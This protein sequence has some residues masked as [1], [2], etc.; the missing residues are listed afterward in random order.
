MYPMYHWIFKALVLYHT[1]DPP[2]ISKRIPGLDATRGARHTGRDGWN[3]HGGYSSAGWFGQVVRYEGGLVA[4]W[5]LSKMKKVR[6]LGW[7]NSQY[8][9]K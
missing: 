2:G 4:G 7:W 9:E 8:M 6:Q 3:A 5:P 1:W